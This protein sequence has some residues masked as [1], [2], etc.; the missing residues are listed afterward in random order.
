MGKT[1]MDTYVIR[2]YRRNENDP[3]IL[4]GVIE[5][6]GAEGNSAF[7]NLDELWSILNSS[8]AKTSKDKKRNRS[9][10]EKK[11]KE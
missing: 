11:A 4:V 3:R 10:N 8:R 2:I 9:L 5:E 7:G 1:F 6:V